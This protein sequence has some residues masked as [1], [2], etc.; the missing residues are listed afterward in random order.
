MRTGI[1]GC[2]ATLALVLS[3]PVTAQV[4]PPEQYKAYLTRAQTIT[5]VMEFGDQISLRD[6]KLS[7]RHVDLE[8]LGNG[9]PIRIIRTTTLDDGLATEA[10]SGNGM[11]G[12]EL[13]IPRIRTITSNAP[14]QMRTKPISPA[15]PV[16]WQ[17]TAAD[18]NARC[19]NFVPPDNVSYPTTGIDFWTSN[20]WFGY[21]LVDDQGNDQPLFN[22]TAEMP[23]QRFRIGTASNWVVEC[24]SSTANGE[25]GEAF[26]A[27]GPDGT[28]YWLNYLVY[29][30]YE[31]LNMEFEN[32]PPKGQ[33]LVYGLP[34]RAASMLVTRVEDRFGNWLAYQ[35]EAGKLTA[36]VASDGRQV[37]IGNPG[38]MIGSIT[39]GTGPEARIWTYQYQSGFQVIQPDGTGWSYTGNFGR[40]F[41]SAYGFENCSQ[42]YNTEPNG[43]RQVSVETPSGAIATFTLQ[44][45]IFGRS[46]VPKYCAGAGGLMNPDAGYALIPRLWIGHAITSK[47][48]SGPGTPPRAWTYTYSPHNGA[49]AENCAGN[50]CTAS[51]WTDV[52]DSMGKRERSYFSNRWD[53]T[54]NKLI[55]EETYNGAGALLRTVEYTYATTP[56]NVAN[57]YPWPQ[58]V[59][60]FA[61]YNINEEVALRWTPLLTRS[62]GQDGRRFVHAVNAFDAWSRPISV[63][64][65]SAPSP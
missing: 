45:R 55:K 38:N 11:G 29:T 51:V 18:K 53:Q 9:P 24:L 17:V 36:I 25:P 31:D 7:F 27:T 34:R 33:T 47:V 56:V 48:V 32:M 10:S 35:Y 50:T 30:P 5:Q 61:G 60:T 39:A 63:T 15:S 65:S 19:T 16:G 6:G 40:Q 12:W 46:Y 14:S 58:K 54:E 52:V 62:V 1:F 21:Q 4:T 64:K 43:T 57:P 13:E 22:R 59:G 28:R 2:Y 49:W 3:S 41:F 8:L 42:L 37:T 23:E 44:R 26:L 20:W